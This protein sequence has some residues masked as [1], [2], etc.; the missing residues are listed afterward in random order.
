MRRRFT[1]LAAL[2]TV[3]AFVL[4]SPLSAGSSFPEEIAL[5]TGFQPEGIATSKGATFF[6]G[7][8]P[9]GAVYRGSLRTGEGAVLVPAQAGRS[10]IGVF[11]DKRNRLFVAGGPRGA[12]YV[13]DARTGA[14]IAM[15][16]F[17]TAPT[18]INDVF[19]TKTGAFFTDSMK[20]ALYR[21]PIGS[22]GELGSTFQTI[23]LTG[24]FVLAPGFNAN[25][26]EG[27]RNGKVLII[28]QSNTGKLFTVSPTG[29]T[30]EITLPP[31]QNVLNGDGMLL[32]G[33][34][35]YVVRNVDREIA[36]V[37]LASNFQ[38]GTIV[39]RITNDRFDTPTT[40]DEHGKRLFVVNARF[41][42]TQPANYWLTQVRKVGGDD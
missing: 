37:R 20:A 28:V 34:N 18:F 32:D 22:N 19:V 7:S 41:G 9:T 21:V 31:G 10:A 6:V 8:I 11:A 16:Q 39:A 1:L 25:G 36:V 17:A 29:V 13:Y 23:P 38:S 24:D 35:L 42:A 2:T 4:A 15:Y 14:N 27:K 5:P 12:G 30:D 3:L 40:V 33:K 26:I